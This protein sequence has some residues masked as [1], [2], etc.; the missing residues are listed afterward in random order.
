MWIVRGGTSFVGGFISNDL[1]LAVIQNPPNK[2]A[3]D[4]A[5]LS[6]MRW[7]VVVATQVQTKPQTHTKWGWVGVAALPPPTHPPAA[8]IG[9]LHCPPTKAMSSGGCSNLPA[10]GGGPLAW[11]LGA[12]NRC[13]GVPEPPST[14]AL[15]QQRRRVKATSHFI[16]RT[17]KSQKRAF[18]DFQMFSN[19]L[20]GSHVEGMVPQTTLSPLSSK[21]KR[22]IVNLLGQGFFRSHNRTMNH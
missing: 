6:A 4:C 20:A 16:F 8:G 15:Q 19:S 3:G 18:P 1:T 13:A 22:Q 11:P 12:H 14:T 5:L 7:S 17:G 10:A 9:A 21:T 2:D